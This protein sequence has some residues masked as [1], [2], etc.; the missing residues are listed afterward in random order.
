LLKVRKQTQGQLTNPIVKEHE[1]EYKREYRL[2]HRSVGGTRK[3]DCEGGSNRACNGR[4]RYRSLARL[5]YSLQAFTCLLRDEGDSYF[6][7][8]SAG[9]AMAGYPVLVSMCG[10]VGLL[11]SLQKVLCLLWLRR[12]SLACPYV[13]DNLHHHRLWNWSPVRELQPPK[14]SSL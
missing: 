1:R 4:L 8:V 7:F 13:R 10:C 14:R 6:D 2:K 11:L 12:E 9:I 5:S 3:G